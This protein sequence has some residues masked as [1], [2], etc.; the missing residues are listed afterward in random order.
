MF[1]SFNI[2]EE[3]DKWIRHTAKNGLYYYFN[4]LVISPFH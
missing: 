3:R 1:E 4:T 2:E